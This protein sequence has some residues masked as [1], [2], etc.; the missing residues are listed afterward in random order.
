MN[1]LETGQIWTHKFSFS[2]NQVAEFA[3]VTGDDNPVHLDADYAAKTAFKRPIVHGMLGA[4]VFSKVFGT[5]YPGPGSLYL[6]QTLD[7][8]GALVVDTDYEALFTVVEEVAKKRFRIRTRIVEVSTGAELVDG[9][10]VIRIT[11]R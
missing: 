10:A 7:F 11:N 3:K 4:C 9:E 6:S 5:I 8:K 1:S 2:Q